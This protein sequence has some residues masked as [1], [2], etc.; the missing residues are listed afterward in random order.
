MAILDKTLTSLPLGSGFTRHSFPCRCPTPNAITASGLRFLRVFGIERDQAIIVAVS[1]TSELKA[2][3]RLQ[4]RTVAKLLLG[5]FVQQSFLQLLVLPE[6]TGIS[7]FDSV[8]L[9]H[10]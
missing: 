3:T 5:T 8:R 4:V 9:H 7:E 1:L 10:T 2:M 6:V